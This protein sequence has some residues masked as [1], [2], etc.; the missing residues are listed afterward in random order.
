MEFETY[1]YLLYNQDDVLDEVVL[2]H[3]NPDM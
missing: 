2:E 3:M 1:A